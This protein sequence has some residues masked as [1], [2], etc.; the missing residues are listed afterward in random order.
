[1]CDYISTTYNQ[2]CE[3][4]CC[5]LPQG[6]YTILLDNLD[7]TIKRVLVQLTSIQSLHTGLDHIERHSRVHSDNSSH[8]AS[9]EGMCGWKRRITFATPCLEP[10]SKRRVAA[11]SDGAVG[12]LTCHDRSQTSVNT[13]QSF[14]F[15]NQ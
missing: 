4:R 6:K 2:T 1:M 8:S 11:E 9:Q 15:D 5:A 13:T 3:T 10:R 14:L 12:A 7:K